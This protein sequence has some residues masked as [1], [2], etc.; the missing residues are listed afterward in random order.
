MH[1]ALAE[2]LALDLES[3]LPIILILVLVLFGGSQLPKLAR[4]L[5]S[6]QREFKKGS[7]GRRREAGSQ[8][9]LEG[10]LSLLPVRAA[11]RT[12]SRRIACQSDEVSFPRLFSPLA[13]GPLVARNRIVCGAH[14]TMYTEPN[15]T[16]GEPGFYGERYGALPRRVRA[17][18]G[19]HGHRRPSAG[20]PHHGVSDAQ[21]RRGVGSAVR[22][23]LGA[24]ERADSR[25]RRARLLA[26]S[27]TT[28]A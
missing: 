11:R 4:G 10:R 14:F 26:S 24:R 18:R 1:S 12:C 2:I 7:E 3:G 8:A 28:A 16:Y 25:V 13:I 20:A 21:Q 23:G 6:A 17:G 15:R 27:R 22:A 9:R 5:G 19:G